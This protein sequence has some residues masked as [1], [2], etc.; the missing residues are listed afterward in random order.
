[1]KKVIFACVHNAGRSQMAAAFFNEIADPARTHA[2]SAGTEPGERVH[3][4]VVAAMQEVGFDLSGSRPQRLTAGLASEARLLIT[5]GCGDACPVVPG[6]IRDDWPLA[7]PKGKTLAVVRAI[8]ED[9]RRR[10]RNLV[11]VEG[12]RATR[13]VEITPAGEPDLEQLEALLRAN[14]LPVVGL[15][16]HFG[17]FVVATRDARVVGAAGIELYGACALLRSVVVVTDL[18]KKGLGGRLTKAALA[19][20]ANEG[21]TSVS[22]LTTTAAGF[23]AA[24]GFAAVSWDA[25]PA[26]LSASAELKG[27]CPRTATAMHRMLDPPGTVTVAADAR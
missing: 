2:I 26:G 27:A 9:I 14:D 10:V 24:Q 8:R 16:E 17:S 21:A 13:A 4:E 18:R 25:L 3:P 23:F 5:M 7:D 12:V 19:R 1:M 11:E 6:A 20:A 15:R 22:L